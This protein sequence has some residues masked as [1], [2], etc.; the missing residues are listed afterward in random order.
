MGIFNRLFE[1]RESRERRE[2]A[3]R[4]AAEVEA[5]RLA[6]EEATAE[7]TRRTEAEARRIAKL[8]ERATMPVAR[9]TA[10]EEAERRSEALPL[11]AQIV[12]GQILIVE[13][14]GLTSG[15][16]SGSTRTHHFAGAAGDLA[17]K[18]A[19]YHK[20]YPHD[21]TLAL[22]TAVLVPLARKMDHDK[23]FSMELRDPSISYA[24]RRSPDFGLTL[25]DL[26]LRIMAL[27]ILR[28]DRPAIEELIELSSAMA[29]LDQSTIM[30][31][32][33]LEEW[34]TLQ[35]FPSSDQARLNA[36]TLGD[37]YTELWERM[38]PPKS[39]MRC[40]STSDIYDFLATS[41]STKS[42]TF[43]DELIDDI[44]HDRRQDILSKYDC[45]GRS[46]ESCMRLLDD[47]MQSMFDE[48]GRLLECTYKWEDLHSGKKTFWYS[49]KT[50][51]DDQCSLLIIV[52]ANGR[53]L[54]A[55]N[56]ALTT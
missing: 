21:L 17:F 39:Q 12:R 32:R 1:S 48:Y 5:Q 6:E 45:K 29:E 54:R 38:S 52:V 49:A 15:Y 16:G 40:P 23:Q 24:N 28:D 51:K 14:P 56:F 50:T 36:K 7:L 33:R 30:S 41:S 13:V 11:D 3:E 27:E 10:L 22:V 25:P 46:P 35:A 53:T 44:I 20:T 37:L 18:C 26:D 8:A 42:K 34:D 9:R 19:A 4:I 43:C 55:R 31:V 2:E 47:H